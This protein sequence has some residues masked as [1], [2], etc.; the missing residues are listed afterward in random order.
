[1]HAHSMHMCARMHIGDLLSIY[2]KYKN[3]VIDLTGCAKLFKGLKAGAEGRKA[4]AEGRGAGG[5]GAEQGRGAGSRGAEGRGAG[6]RGAEGLGGPDHTSDDEPTY[7]P[8]REAT[9]MEVVRELFTRAKADLALDQLVVYDGRGA[10][11]RSSSD[12]KLAEA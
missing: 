11:F 3:M 7:T 1:M 12:L 8:F 2:N 6:S 10:P 9:E 5:R 4:G